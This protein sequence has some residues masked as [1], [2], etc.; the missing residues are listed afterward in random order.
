MKCKKTLKGRDSRPKQHMTSIARAPC[1]RTSKASAVNPKAP[2]E[3]GSCVAKIGARSY[4]TETEGGNLYRGNRKFIRQ[5][6]SQE[7]APSDRSGT[8]LPSHAESPT[9][10]LP[11]A[12]ADSPSKQAP[13]M[14][15][16]YERHQSK[17]L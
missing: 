2:W 3:K 8:N 6:P 15:Q 14:R 16:T 12:K 13:T 1:R 5:D 17:R 11:D 9:E 4:L 7:L 10:S